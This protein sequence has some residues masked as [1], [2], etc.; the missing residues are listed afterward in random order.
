MCKSLLLAI[1]VLYNIIS[2]SSVRCCTNTVFELY[3]KNGVSNHLNCVVYQCMASLLIRRVT[4]FSTDR[5]L[6]KK[7]YNK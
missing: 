5:F 1:Q 6:D 2:L 3:D 7:N 4:F